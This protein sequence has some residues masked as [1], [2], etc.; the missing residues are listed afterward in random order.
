VSANRRPDP[1]DYDLDEIEVERLMAGDQTIPLYRTH[2][3]GWPLKPEAVE[4]VRRLAGY[5]YSDR[6]VSDRLGG[7]IST[8][9][10]EKV[11]VRYGVPAGAQCTRPVHRRELDH[12][13]LLD[14]HAAGVRVDEMVRRSGV[15][16]SRIHA[17][18]DQLGLPRFKPGNPR[19][20]GGAA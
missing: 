17:A 7:R 4:A 8:G 20:F 3:R 14:W 15:G 12:G 11:R 13:Q 5:G 9:G 16:R 1:D 10:V 19:W 2:L 6:M 18:M